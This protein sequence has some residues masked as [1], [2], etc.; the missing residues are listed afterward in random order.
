MSQLL[1]R[2]VNQI[3][4]HTFLLGALLALGMTACGPSS[5]PPSPDQL[6][7]PGE[8]P[9]ERN[10]PSKEK[11]FAAL[12]NS[13]REAKSPVTPWASTYWPF[14][15]NGI[16]TGKY[17]R[18][19]SPAGKYDAARGLTTRAQQWELEHHGSKT[20][21]VEPWWGH[22]PGWSTAA[23][24]FEEPRASKIV[25]G[26]TFTV[27]DQKALI[28]EAAMQANSEFFGFRVDH[29]QDFN[30]FKY[31]DVAP[32]QFFLVLTN[33][34]GKLRFPVL[35]DQDPGTQVWNQPLAGYR[36]EYPSPND[37]LGANSEAPNIYR[38]NL[39]ATVWWAS[40]AISPEVETP[41]FNWEVSSY[42]ETRTYRMELWLDGPVL[43]DG[44]G[45]I[46]SSGD[47]VVVRQGDALL[48]GAWTN[49]TLGTHPDYMWVPTSL[50]N[51]ADPANF[52][53]DDPSYV[54]TQVD[55]NWVKNY[56][57]PG[58][59]DPSVRPSPVPTAPVATPT[60]T[61][62]APGPGASPPPEPIPVPIPSPTSG[63]MPDV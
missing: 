43:F 12:I 26:I 63:S 9:G 46:T 22:C 44:S 57:I 16:A 41:E 30:N 20:R 23:V 53:D 32:D 50:L 2:Y 25:N 4:F 37:Y 42:F 51:P 19:L 8:R 34:L 35:I 1:G 15:D 5:G 27:A 61:P 14:V 6:G 55:L 38:I 10:V 3:D 40:D 33:Y 11:N 39:T 17:G 49:G 13:Y 54:N 36:L 21:G 28:T 56:L 47:L 48:G 59:D 62:P 60:R 31:N 29:A 45:R 58:R 24:F 7:L 18:G 52:S